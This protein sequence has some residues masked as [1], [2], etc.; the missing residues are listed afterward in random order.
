MFLLPYTE[1]ITTDEPAGT[2]DTPTPKRPQQK[3][4][5]FRVNAAGSVTHDKPLTVA[6]NGSWR[7]QAGEQVTMLKGE[8]GDAGKLT[9]R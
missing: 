9:V 3:L 8:F 5:R 1:T 4:H 6:F 2:H 7:S